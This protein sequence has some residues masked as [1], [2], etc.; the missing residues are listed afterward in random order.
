MTETLLPSNATPIEIAIEQAIDPVEEIRPALDLITG[1]KH[2]LQPPDLRPYL[3]DE[4]GMHV[5]LPYVPNYADILSARLP[6]CEVRGTHEAVAQ[7]LAMVGYSG[8]L[9]DPPSRR[10]AWAEFQIDLDRVRDDR[11][12][13]PKIA[14]IVDLSIPERSTFRRGMHGYDVPAIETAW[15]RLGEA[16]LGDDSGVRIN[17]EGPKWSYGRPYE[18]EHTLTEADLTA[19]G[20]WIPEVPSQLWVDMN[21]L[22]VTANFKWS[23]DAE[24]AR[25][26]SL[27][28]SIEEKPVWLRFMTAGGDTIGFRRAIAHGVR[29]GLDGYAFGSSY[30]TLDPENPTGVYLFARTGFGDG[31]GSEAASVSVVFDADVTDAAKPGKL[32]LEAGGLTGGTEIAAQPISIL[33]GETVREHIQFF[34]RF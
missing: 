16:M 17:G 24:R 1:W 26:V 19:L 29:Q 23:D 14:G 33:F 20:I 32:W 25:R 30:L 4:F 31:F 22:W 5:L 27:A 12:D 15:T 3:V 8:T 13:L 6:W 11:D 2:S 34:L 21:F 10:M 9:V 28:S 7:G 18:F